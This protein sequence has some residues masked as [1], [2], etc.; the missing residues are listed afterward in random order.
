MT[1]KSKTYKAGNSEYRLKELTLGVMHHA[2]PLF[3]KYRELHFE[4]TGGIDTSELEGMQHQAKKLELALQQLEKSNSPDEAQITRLL[5]KLKETKAAL[6]TDAKLKNIRK[7]LSDME[8]I[9]LYSLITDK[10]L[11]GKVLPEIM[12]SPAGN[13]MTASEAAAIL[14]STDSLDFVKDAVTDFFSLTLGI[15]KKQNG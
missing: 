10:E 3:R 4:F 15:M 14:K 9:V 11:L 1:E 8:A 12:E 6:N 2:V 7:Y 5:T 13:S